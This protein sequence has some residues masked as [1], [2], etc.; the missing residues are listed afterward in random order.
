[1]ST[2]PPSDLAVRICALL[3]PLAGSE[4][5]RAPEPSDLMVLAAQAI[6][7]PARRLLVHEDGLTPTLERHWGRTLELHVLVES[8]TQAELWRHVHL[9]TAG[10]RRL[11]SF[12]AIHLALE[13]FSPRARAPILESRVPLGTILREHAV[14]H[15]RRV[16][17][18]F[19]IAPT[20]LPHAGLGTG[21][22]AARLHGRHSVLVSPAGEA[23]AEVV[24]I[25]A[26]TGDAAAA[27][28]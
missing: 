1:M 16:S 25:L 3:A 20:R 24:E 13:R 7:E 8:R 5:G 19:A 11:V 27:G 4:N 6:P 21:N 9:V 14:A 18:F 26:G 12:G 15:R 2:N 10:D 17:G 23:M 22:V 28:P